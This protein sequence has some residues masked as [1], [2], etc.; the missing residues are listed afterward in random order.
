MLS[1][2]KIN[3]C[4][5]LRTGNGFAK[6]YWKRCYD[7]WPNPKSL[8][9][10]ERGACLECIAVCHEGHTVDSKVRY[11]NFFCDCG[12]ENKACK[13]SVG[14]APMET[15]TPYRPPTVPS[16]PPSNDDERRNI[17]PFPHPIPH[18]TPFFPPQQ[19]SDPRFPVQPMAPPPCL[20]SPSHPSLVMGGTPPSPPG[21]F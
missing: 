4:T 16:A 12:L 18:P 2:S 20:M 6:Q 14:Q 11:G 10:A 21:T 5:Y 13:L 19:P 1:D 17:F 9:E 7:C 15:L 3:C 8:D